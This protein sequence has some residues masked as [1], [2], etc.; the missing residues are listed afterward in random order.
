MILVE[1][2]AE[3]GVLDDILDSCLHSSPTG[4]VAII[5]GPPGIGKSAL[6]HT[7]TRRAAA[8]GG[9]VI[10]AT[11]GGGGEPGPPLGMVHQLLH[12]AARDSRHHRDVLRALDDY[13]AVTADADRRREDAVY[14]RLLHSVDALLRD[15]SLQGPIM[16]FL[17]DVQEADPASLRCLSYIMRRIT[18]VRSLVALTERTG[19]FIR[20]P[21]ATRDVLL[22]PHVTRVRLR[23]LSRQGVG[24]MIEDQVGPVT[25]LVAEAVH[26]MTGGN[27]LLVRAL[28]ED[29]QL[30]PGAAARPAAE[31]VPGAG[32]EGAVLAC[33]HRLDPTVADV[34][35]ALAVFGGP[36]RPSWLGQVLDIDPDQAERA[37]LVLAQ[38]GLVERGRFRHAT[39]AQVVYR[40]M[41][42]DRRSNLHRRAAQVLYVDGAQAPDV[43]THL[44]AAR[45]TGDAWAVPV[46]RAASAESLR[47]QP[48][49]AVAFLNL[50]AQACSDDG[51]R[52]AILARAAAI[53]WSVNPAAVFRYLPDLVTAAC[54]GRLVGRQGIGLVSA[55]AWHGLLAQASAAL[56][57]VARSSSQ[58]SDRA[59]AEF[60]TGRL[61]LLCTYPGL[62]SDGE[63]VSVASELAAMRP[64]ARDPG[65]HAALSLAAVLTGG[66][67]ALT[68]EEATQLI[69]SAGPVT[70]FETV[71][72]VLLGLLYADRLDT[73]HMWAEVLGGEALV[74]RS[75]T[76]RALLAGLRAEIALRRGELPVADT[77]GRTALADIPPPGWGVGLSALLANRMLAAT[78]MGRL[79]EAAEHARIPVPEAVYQSLFGLHYLHARGRFHLAG[80]RPH[81][82]LADF[83][84]CG[85]LMV[86]WGVDVSGLVPWRIDAAEAHLRLGHTD[87]SRRLAEEQLTRET[88]DRS[89][90]TGNA[91][92]LLA[93]TGRPEDRVAV[94]R[95][96]VDILRSAGARVDLARAL[97]DLGSAYHVAGDPARARTTVR[98]ARLLANQSQAQVVDDPVAGPGRA[99]GRS[100]A[101]GGKEPVGPPRPRPASTALS[102]LTEAERRVAALA[103]LGHTNG[104]IAEAL[105]ITVSTVE[106]HLTKVYRKLNVRSRADLP[107]LPDTR[108][109]DPA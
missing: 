45:H 83:A 98:A 99:G 41:S 61:L 68:S 1:R 32:Y 52:T 15:L 91:L 24:L 64:A 51:E 2:D 60:R 65:T 102:P 82:A 89:R 14:T 86:R 9:T 35:R 49:R 72:P 59:L 96:A 92:R 4:R 62:R 30:A 95:R 105:Y 23:P 47:E 73:A 78:E 46:L 58:H 97:S 103:A 77:Y 29:H 16:I 13:A 37:Q 22:Q 100:R 93:T 34:A 12:A 107:V 94:L 63:S 79:G 71:V 31:L 18:F 20:D 27:P 109:A 33:L 25:D 90:A 101:V 104:E 40:D 36:G 11:G 66:P 38:T 48:S 39:A 7:F 42:P 70:R 6:L 75:P 81:D 108:T 76:W 28:A 43:A 67:V 69:D 54:D 57:W 106:Q 88:D 74:H 21:A 56:G 85:D 10:G 17:D 44:L 87:R 5:S 8:S 80:G 19:G 3:I 26:T 55:L 50:A 84:R 53:D